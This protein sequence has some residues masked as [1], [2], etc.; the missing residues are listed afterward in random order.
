MLNEIY[1]KLNNS[2][3]NKKSKREKKKEEGKGVKTF[4]RFSF[5]SELEKRFSFLLHFMLKTW[6]KTRSHF[7][8]YSH[9]SHKV[10]ELHKKVNFLQRIALY[11]SLLVR[12]N[13]NGILFCMLEPQ[14]DIAAGAFW[15]TPTPWGHSLFSQ[16]WNS[17]SDHSIFWSQ[18]IVTFE[19]SLK[20]R[21]LSKWP[22]CET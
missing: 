22:Q 12:S 13:G 2:E 18:R 3:S 21:D 1:T 10:C 19:K 4:N 20:Q 8:H 17:R 6:S 16:K 7:S 14:P 5:F 11:Y 9:F 15:L